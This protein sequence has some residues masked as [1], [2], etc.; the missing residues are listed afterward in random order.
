[1][2]STFW[3]HDLLLA[4]DDTKFWKCWNEKFEKK[5]SAPSKVNGFLDPDLIAAS[6]YA[7]LRLYVLMIGMKCLVTYVLCTI[8]DGTIMLDRRL[9]I[10]IWLMPNWLNKCIGNMHR[11]K[12]AGL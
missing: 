5:I 11:G 8:I 9:I 7:V 10:C 2:N 4:K 1:M 6:L 12:A 3:L